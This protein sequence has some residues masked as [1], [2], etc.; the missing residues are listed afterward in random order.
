MTD[1]D[2]VRRRLL[3]AGARPGFAGRMTDVRYDRD[4]ELTGRGEVLRLRTYHAPEADRAILGWKGPVSV[5]VLGHKERDELEYPIQSDRFPPGAL[6]EALRYTAMQIIER[7][8]EYYHLEDIAIRL[9]W[10]PRMDLLIEIEGDSE[11]IARGIMATG[12]SRDAFTP[13]PLLAFTNRYSART[14]G[15]AA[16]RLAELGSEPPRWPNP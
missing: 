2:L 3:A 10:Y 14:G 16:L 1:P 12:L 4:G 8:V 13:E 6:L 11:G 7:Y 9:E 15:P 5:S